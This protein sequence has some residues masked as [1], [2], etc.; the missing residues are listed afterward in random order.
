ME[1]VDASGR[2]VPREVYNWET[3]ATSV[4]ESWG[5]EVSSETYDEI[6]KS[7]VANGFVEKREFG[8]KAPGDYAL[9]YDRSVLNGTITNW[10]VK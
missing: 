6:R 1:T 10:G 4:V 2:V 9:T 5:Q 8:H 3:K 7:K